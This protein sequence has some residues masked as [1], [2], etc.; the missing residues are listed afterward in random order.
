MAD[1]ACKKL[2]QE[3]AKQAEWATSAVVSH[4]GTVLA[5]EPA[6]AAAAGEEVAQLMQLY[7]D[8][9]ATVGGG[10]R[11]GGKQYEVQRMHGNLVYGRLEEAREKEGFCVIRSEAASTGAHVY[12]VITYVSPTVSARAIPQL[13][14][15]AKAHLETL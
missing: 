4:D 2:R 9:D 11:W 3:L 1:A 7:D 5:A 10:L 6:D 14:A 13:Q 12:A 15:F 8:R